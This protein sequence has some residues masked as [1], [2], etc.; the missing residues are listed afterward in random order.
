[1]FLCSSRYALGY[2]NSVRFLVF[3]T[4]GAIPDYLRISLILHVHNPDKL[5]VY[6]KLS[7]YVNIF[8]CAIR[9]AL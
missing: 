1:M 7:D 8:P 6:L 4:E 9:E 3:Q 5:G 2:I